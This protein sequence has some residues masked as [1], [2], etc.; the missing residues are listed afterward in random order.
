MVKNLPAIQETGVQSLGRED[1]LEE[2][3]PTHSSIHAW[4][5]VLRSGMEP[6]PL[7]VES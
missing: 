5:L 4:I 7:S 2:E 6:M 3:I 1:P